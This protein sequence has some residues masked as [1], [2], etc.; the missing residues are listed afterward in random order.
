MRD[1]GNWPWLLI[2]FSI[3]AAILVVFAIMM[4]FFLGQWTMLF[5][6]LGESNGQESRSTTARNSGLIVAGALALLFALWRGIV[7]QVQSRTE[8]WRL[9]F[10]QY[11]NGTEMLGSDILSVRL[12]GIYTLERLAQEN[13]DLYHIQVMRQLCSFVRHPIKVEDQPIVGTEDVSTASGRGVRTAEEFSAAE[14]IELCL[15]REDVQQAMEAI[16][17]CHNK[18]LE[19]ETNQV[20]RV[21]LH[22]ADLRGA[23]LA[24]MNLSPAPAT[25]LYT[26]LR[27]VRLKDA[28][29]RST[30]VS[31][32]DL[33]GASGLTQQSLSMAKAAPKHPPR[34]MDTFEY[35]GN[36]LEWSE[37]TH[38]QT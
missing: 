13:P 5:G 21:D 27:G 16:A 2:S 8:Q 9:L 37:L 29:L 19:I 11:R 31:G 20:Y 18:N 1:I 30:N 15:L 34:L 22:D 35:R 26:D 14:V 24:G 38:S 23:N 17:S 12:G 6:W 10:D 32:V 25:G 4:Y 28:S 7:A 3:F 36:K 33:S